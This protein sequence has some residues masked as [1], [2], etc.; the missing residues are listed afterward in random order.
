MVTIF[1]L[2]TGDLWT[3]I[4][5]FTVHIEKNVWLSALIVFIFILGHF[6][7]LNLFLA[8]LLRAI[9]KEDKDQEEE[10]EKDEED[11]NKEIREL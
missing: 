3:D 9:S 11:E 6:M 1:V 10:A 2:L 7:L 4:M 8:V 5:H